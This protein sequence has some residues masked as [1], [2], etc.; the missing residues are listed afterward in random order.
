MILNKNEHGFSCCKISETE[1][2]RLFCFPHA[3]A[4]ATVYALWGRYMPENISLYPVLY[5]AREQRRNEAF[6]EKLTEL[7]RKIAVENKD[8][9]CEKPFVLYGH[10]EGGI[11]AYETAVFLKELCGVSPK[12]LVASGANP[13][14]IQTAELIKENMTME[15]A[16]K[17]FAEY[18]FLNKDFI[19]NKMY[20]DCFVPI[21]VKDFLLLQNYCD[22]DHKKL[23]C[24]I[25][26]M[27]GSDDVNIDSKNIHGWKEYTF[28]D[29]EEKVFNGG[30]FF[31]TKDNIGSVIS[32][33]CSCFSDNI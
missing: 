33:M 9:F 16:A 13:P 14:D 5:P 21:L 7:A 6:P 10:C 32:S 22:K 25:L 23:D 18:G 19:G 11:I 4:G 29:C 1:S 3:G 8:A 28:A 15:E 31:I 30:H 2:G 24:P 17:V 20:M 12:L 27:Y 26:L